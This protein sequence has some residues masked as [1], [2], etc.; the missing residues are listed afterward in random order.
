MGGG[1][2]YAWFHVC[3]GGIPGTRSLLEADMFRGYVWGSICPVGVG[4]S[5]G[6]YPGGWV[7]P[8]GVGTDPLLLTPSG[9]Y[10]MY[11]LQAGGT[12]LT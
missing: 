11:G 10:Y 3:F 1:G 5:R 2:G 6:V 4:M 8:R 9:S 7:C 12:Y